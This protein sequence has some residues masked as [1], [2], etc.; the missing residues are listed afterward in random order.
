MGGIASFGSTSSRYYFPGAFRTQWSG[1]KQPWGQRAS[2]RAAACIAAAKYWPSLA[3]VLQC[4]TVRPVG[5]RMASYDVG[6]G[7]T[8]SGLSLTAGDVM[9]FFSAGVATATTVNG[10][11]VALGVSVDAGGSVIGLLVETGAREGKVP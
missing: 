3:S 5:P 6:S 1:L 8:S 7:Q 9:R 10:G 4:A 11:G 2:Q